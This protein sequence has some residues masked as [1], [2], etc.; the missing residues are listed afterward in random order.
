MHTVFPPVIHEVVHSCEDGPGE[1]KPGGNRLNSRAG[2]MAVFS[3]G[4]T[5]RV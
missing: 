2:G 1:G 3:A 4:L 5:A